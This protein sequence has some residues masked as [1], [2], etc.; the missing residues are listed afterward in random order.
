MRGSFFPSLGHGIRGSEW[1]QVKATRFF[2]CHIDRVLLF[3]CYY[4]A[5]IHGCFYE[6]VTGFFLNCDGDGA[7]A[8]TAFHGGS[9]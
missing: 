1:Y 8:G 2:C 9:K 5:S 7:G 4:I 6:L 3:V